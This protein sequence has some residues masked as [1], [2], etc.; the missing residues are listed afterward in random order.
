MKWNLGQVSD[1]HSYRLVDDSN[2]VVGN[3][4]V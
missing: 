2:E 4:T 1:R 3:F